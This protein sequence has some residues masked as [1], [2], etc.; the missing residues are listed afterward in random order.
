MD[1]SNVP[2]ANQVQPGGWKLMWFRRN[3]YYFYLPAIA[4]F[5]IAASWS[6]Y[7]S[8]SKTPTDLPISSHHEK[9]AGLV[10]RETVPY[11]NEKYLFELLLPVDWRVDELTYPGS[12]CFLSP[13]LNEA[14]RDRNYEGLCGDLVF[15]TRSYQNSQKDEAVV[16]WNGVNFT[17][18]MGG[19]AYETIN[20]SA[21]KDGRIYNFETNG[22]EAEK[23]LSTFRFSE[24][25]KNLVKNAPVDTSDKQTSGNQMSI[26]DFAKCLA[27][28]KAVMYGASWCPHCQNEKKAFGSSW[29]YVSYVECTE[30]PDACRAAGVQGYP[31]WMLSDGSQIPGEQNIDGFKELAK[32][33]F[34][35]APTK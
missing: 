30:N 20:Y 10:R 27:G 17:R 19:A 3:R 32:A 22:R 33:T 18:Y 29:Q 24:S 25:V 34:C 35:P 11:K 5:T 14:I 16:S 13:S 4:I 1:E 31:T 28:K 15:S 7:Y 21:D 12:I 23:I 6:H 9:A 2:E 26:E 8:V